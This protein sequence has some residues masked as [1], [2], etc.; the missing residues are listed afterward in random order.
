MNGQEN[1]GWNMAW[2]GVGLT[3]AGFLLT[4]FLSSAESF[5][6]QGIPYCVVASALNCH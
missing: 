5:G 1:H 2:A 6:L 3:V 4:C